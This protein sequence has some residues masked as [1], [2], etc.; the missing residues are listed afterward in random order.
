MTQGC[1][2]DS[3]DQSKH[4]GIWTSLAAVLMPI[5]GARGFSALYRRSVL[6]CVNDHPWMSECID[7][8][9]GNVDLKRLGRVLA[10][11]SI[12]EANAASASL[13]KALRSVLDGLIGRAL[14]S[15]LFDDATIRSRQRVS[16]DEE[17][18]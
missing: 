18:G 16:G 1:L 12:E 6:L 2:D 11:Q 8:E 13:L 10:S 17:P 7:A 5:I 15:T 14:T 3:N 9:L 4:H